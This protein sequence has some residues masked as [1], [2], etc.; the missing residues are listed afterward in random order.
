MHMRR[1]QCILHISGVGSGNSQLTRSACMCQ[2]DHPVH[3]PYV[4]IFGH[5]L[6]RAT[7]SRVAAASVCTY[8]SSNLRLVDPWPAFGTNRG[9]LPLF[10][11]ISHRPI[12]LARTEPRGA[13]HCHLIRA[14]EVR[15]CAKD[16]DIDEANVCEAWD[17]AMGFVAKTLD[18]SPSRPVRSGFH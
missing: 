3:A 5:A 18:A 7:S 12:P 11:D 8:R 4:R 14:D 10:H 2:S 9:A 16:I 6:A 1:R 15:G 17:I 13:C